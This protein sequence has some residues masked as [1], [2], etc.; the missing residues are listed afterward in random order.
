MAI[1]EEREAHTTWG[2]VA[3]RWYRLAADRHPATGRLNHHLGILERPSLRKLFLYSKSLTCVIPFINAKDSLATL[4]NP[5]VQNENTTHQ[6][7]QT[8]EARLVTSYAMIF[9]G[10]DPVITK[11]TATDALI[12]LG[13]QPAS[14][15]RDYGVEMVV[16]GVGFLL[17]LGTPS[18]G[19]WQSF[20]AAINNVARASRPSGVA[21]SPSSLVA[22]PQ[23]HSPLATTFAS[24]LVYDFS[25]RTFNSIFRH[26]KDRQ[27]LRNV[28][29]PV[30]TILVWLHSIL[31]VG[32]RNENS[33]NANTVGSLVLELVDWGELSEFL[34]KMLQTDPVSA[35]TME[36]A[37][38]GMFL[39]PE[40]VEDAQPLTEDLVIRGLIWTQFYHPT[41][42]FSSPI[43]DEAR[44]IE[45]AGMHKAR[46]ER[47]QWL[48]LYLA[49]RIDH[50]KYNANTRSFYAP[51]S[52]TPSTNLVESE[53][54][55]DQQAS[56][57]GQVSPT[58][59]SSTTFS[60]NSDS[61]DGFAV[62]TS[63]R[64]KPNKAQ[65]KPVRNPAK[66][67]RDYSAVHV[68]DQDSMQWEQEC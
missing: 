60:A 21:A 30:H 3:G 38:Q 33:L 31:T 24:Q 39:T 61:S 8:A 68:V 56:G 27:S 52:N 28:L 55:F 43:E 46:V 22:V 67:R 34:N 49:F 65:S 19:L 64:R 62:V 48:A 16:T 53:F 18:N 35:R 17:E 36:F 32:S 14:K 2:S 23:E 9:L 1:E 40:R 5:L 66:S 50:L 25:F 12:R 11:K 29:A 59:R 26:R 4:C 20:A 57:A 51:A 45:T 42:W 15:L 6:G 7:A 41:D 63:S 10:Y 54:T 44:T 47:V 58:S 37:R 13:S